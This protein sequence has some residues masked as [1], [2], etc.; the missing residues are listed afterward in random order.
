MYGMTLPATSSTI[1]RR[2]ERVDGADGEHDEHAAEEAGHS[3]QARRQTT[4][5]PTLERVGR[6][7]PEQSEERIAHFRFTIGCRTVGKSRDN[8]LSIDFSVARSV[9]IVVAGVFRS[10][11]YRTPVPAAGTSPASARSSSSSPAHVLGQ[12]VAS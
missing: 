8:G 3:A 11:V 10:R 2:T 5:Q 1:G 4:H 6:H 12:F 7:V 9:Y